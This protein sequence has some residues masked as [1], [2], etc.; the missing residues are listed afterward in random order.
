MGKVFPY[1]Y[2]TEANLRGKSVNFKGFKITHFVA[3]LKVA[4]VIVARMAIG[5]WM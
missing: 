3:V 2:Q 1:S 4:A 5:R